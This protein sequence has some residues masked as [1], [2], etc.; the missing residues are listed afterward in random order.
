[1]IVERLWVPLTHSQLARH[2]NFAA[3]GASVSAWRAP[4]NASMFTPLSTVGASVCVDITV[5]D[6]T[7]PVPGQG[8][9]AAPGFDA[10]TGWGVPNGS[11]LVR[12]G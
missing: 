8:Y 4:R 3:S 6:N 9:A 10:V 11:A 5:G 2:W 1:M 7:T 12:L